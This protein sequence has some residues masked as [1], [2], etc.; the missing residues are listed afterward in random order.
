V[1]GFRFVESYLVRTEKI[2]KGRRSWPKTIIICENNEEVRAAFKARA[3]WACT[4]PFEDQD[5]ITW[6]RALSDDA[7][8]LCS[9]YLSELT[10]TEVR[11]EQYPVFLKLVQESL[12]LLF[13]PDLVNPDKKVVWERLNT[14]PQGRLI[15][16][17]QANRENNAGDKNTTRF[18]EFWKD[19]RQYHDAKHVT[20][21]V[22][23]SEILSSAIQN[24]GRYLS[25]LHGSIGLVIGR[26]FIRSKI[27]PL[28]IALFENEKKIILL[29]SDLEIQEMLEYKAG[30]VNPACLLQD[31]YQQLIADAEN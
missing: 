12:Q 10:S 15:F 3:D 5:L 26:S 2:K 16:R 11:K 24:L 4:V 28:T 30:G 8:W 18:N 29:L 27:Y 13:H 6:I 1:A 14:V 9:E 20:A 25:T 17:N 22:Y 19:M 7:K 31:L 21:D 23:N